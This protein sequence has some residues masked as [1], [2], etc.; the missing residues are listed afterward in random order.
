MGVEVEKRLASQVCAPH[1]CHAGLGIFL[2]A[3]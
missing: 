3:G 1:L 2:V